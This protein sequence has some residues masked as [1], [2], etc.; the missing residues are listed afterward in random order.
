MSILKWKSLQKKFTIPD[1]H[2]SVATTVEM[3]DLGSLAN[4]TTINTTVKIIEISPPEIVTAKSGK[5]YT[6]QDCVVGDNSA[7]GRVVL[8]QHD[9]NKLIVG[10]SYKLIVVGVH[11]FSGIN[12]LS[13]T[14]QSVIQ[15]VS[16]I[17]DICY[18][19][20]GDVD[21][22]ILSRIIQG[23]IVGARVVKYIGCST[24]KIKIE[25]VDTM[26]GK[27]SKCGLMMTL[28]KCPDNF[29]ANI[30]VEDTTKKIMI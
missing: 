2:M 4:N 14:E 26:V 25:V 24:C 22:L 6:K 13:V 7:C 27:C 19:E 8:W 1:A 20:S 17:G 30:R 9:V 16:D 23:E 10:N 29:I 18:L 12:Y 15:P 11:L 21:R 3:A 28:S 5:T